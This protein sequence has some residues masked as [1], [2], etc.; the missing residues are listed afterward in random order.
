MHR[1]FLYDKKLAERSRF[2]CSQ[3]LLRLQLNQLVKFELIH[4]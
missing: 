3:G 4:Y 2:G 1:G